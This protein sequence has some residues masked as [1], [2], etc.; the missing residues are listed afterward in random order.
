MTD[1]DD[2][3][4]T[5][6]EWIRRGRQ[7]FESGKYAP[8]RGEFLGRIESWGLDVFE[9]S[10]ESWKDALRHERRRHGENE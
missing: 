5:H 7:I 2:Y 6:A 3:P 10:P 8:K 9:G 1:D 4:T